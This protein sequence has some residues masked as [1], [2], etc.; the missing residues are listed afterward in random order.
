MSNVSIVN[1][2]D[3]SPCL[4]CLGILSCGRPWKAVSAWVFLPSPPTAETSVHVAFLFYLP[5]QPS[6]CLCS[7]SVLVEAVVELHS[8][9]PNEEKLC[10]VGCHC[11]DHTSIS[12][13]QCALYN[14]RS[15]S[16]LV[17]EAAGCERNQGQ[18]EERWHK[19]RFTTTNSWETPDICLCDSELLRLIVSHDVS[20]AMLGRANIEPDS[21][22]TKRES[23]CCV[24]TRRRRKSQKS[25]LTGGQCR[26]SGSKGGSRA[27]WWTGRQEQD[28]RSSLGRCPPFLCARGHFRWHCLLSSINSKVL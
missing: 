8:H 1:G 19:D 24:R 14:V 7:V 9:L 6:F 26:H 28:R 3:P 12:V 16:N 11:C 27:Q 18:S 15:C 2:H 10:P 20:L 21:L 22:G 13:C 25:S 17:S 4:P 5:S 23:L